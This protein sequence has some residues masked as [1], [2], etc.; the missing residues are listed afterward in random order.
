MM[1]GAGLD[2]AEHDRLGPPSRR[3]SSS[4]DGPLRGGR[5]RASVALP[6]SSAALVLGN[7]QGVVLLDMGTVKVRRAQ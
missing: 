5:R 2:A 3:L 1:F 4:V 7:F 6:E